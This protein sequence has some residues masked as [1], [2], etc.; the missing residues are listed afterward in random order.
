MKAEFTSHIGN[1]GLSYGTEAEFNFRMGL[2]SEKDKEIAEINSDPSNTFTVGHNMFSTW[3]GEEA[4]RMMGLK[5]NKNV[6]EATILPETKAASVDW[7]TK[8]AVTA[9]KNQGQCGSCWSFAAVAAVEGAH[10][11]IG[12]FRSLDSLSD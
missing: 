11:I 3:T 5:V 6:K 2:Y 9:V 7:R 4:K 10:A 1:Y 12:G 8:N